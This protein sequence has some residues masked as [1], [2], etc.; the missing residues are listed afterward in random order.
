[1]PFLCPR[2]VLT[3]FFP[4]RKYHVV[5]GHSYS[6]AHSQ[7]PLVSRNA[8]HT[9]LQLIV[10]SVIPSRSEPG[11]PDPAASL[12][13]LELLFTNMHHVLNEFRP[14]QGHETLRA[15]M[16]RQ[17]EERDAMTASL[18]ACF[19]DARR[20]LAAL[21]SPFPSGEDDT[22]SAAGGGGGAPS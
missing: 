21:V 10:L 7:L 18:R 16:E 14:H 6:S 4:P 20:Q 13:K 17:L 3:A 22:G 1:M 5:T 15:M 9:F 11:A 8:F 12:A 2:N 19:D